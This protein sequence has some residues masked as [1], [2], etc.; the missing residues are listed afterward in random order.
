MPE[1]R[2]ESVRRRFAQLHESANFIL[3]NPW[4]VGSA[5]LLETLGFTA[6][7]T[8]SSGFAASLGRMDMATSRTELVDHVASLTAA[9]ALPINVDAER[10]FSADPAGVEETINLLA[11]A[12]ASGISIEDF[13]PER[14]GMDPVDVAAER[15]AVAAVACRRH[16]ITL[17]GR[18]ENHIRGVDDLDDTIAR[19]LAY[20]E[21]GANVLYAPGLSDIDHIARVVSVTGTPINVLAL[22]NGPSVPELAAVGVRRVSTGGSLAWAAYG[23]LVNAAQEL[24]TAGTSTYLGQAVSGKLRSTAFAPR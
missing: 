15:V 11:E 2:F 21:A 23:A 10:C 1:P 20:R 13:D 17:T 12:G 18:A 19:L 24:Q 22:A 4:D 16:G 7:A 8:T 3:P 9:V 5:R 14:G 6:L